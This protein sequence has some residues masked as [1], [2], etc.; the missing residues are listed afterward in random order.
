MEL[1][2]GAGALALTALAWT[3][4]L[5]LT[6]GAMALAWVPHLLVVQAGLLGWAALGSRWRSAALFALGLGGSAAA[7]DAGPPAASAAGS[8]SPAGSCAEIVAVNAYQWNERRAEEIDEAL[9]AAGAP[10]VMFIEP[11]I[12]LV[13][14]IRGLGRWRA[15]ARHEVSGK[16]D[17]AVLVRGD[18]RPRAW[19]ERFDFTGSVIGWVE[20]TCDGAPVRV[21]GVHLPA[22]T[23]RAQQSERWRMADL[24]SERAETSTVPFALAGD[25][26][27]TPWSAL[28]RRMAA[29]GL[30]PLPGFREASW[31]TWLGPLGIPIDHAVGS[32]GVDGRLERFELPGS[33]HLGF[34]LRLA[35]SDPHRGATVLERQPAGGEEPGDVDRTAERDAPEDAGRGDEVEHREH[36][37]ARRGGAPVAAPGRGGQ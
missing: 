4:H 30:R 28:M 22:P 31:P 16:Y 12:G 24:L 20:V 6:V 1:R 32:G 8:R 15:P 14:A 18:A 17:L 29:G 26:N 35:G 9:T 7:L 21:G 13:E 25:F 2:L 37:D 36:R 23:T 10:V 27:A 11:R 19:I 33:D 5:R 34:V 3:A